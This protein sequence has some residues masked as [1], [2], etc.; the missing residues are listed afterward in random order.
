MH[1]P[2]HAGC[3]SPVTEDVPPLSDQSTHGVPPSMTGP[4]LSRSVPLH[5]TSVNGPVHSWSVHSVNPRHANMPTHVCILSWTYPAELINAN[6]GIQPSATMC[7]QPS[8]TMHLQP[9]EMMEFNTQ[10][11]VF[12]QRHLVLSILNGRQH[13]LDPVTIN[14][15]FEQIHR[16]RQQRRHTPL[17]L[18]MSTRA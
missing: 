6:N 3:S 4:V 14:S 7:I 13:H 10:T 18:M 17:L 9:S 16:E 1:P 2:L 11:M 5:P 12:L 8:A 15:D